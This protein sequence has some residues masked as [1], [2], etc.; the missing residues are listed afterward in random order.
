MISARNKI[1]KK[2]QITRNP[3]YKNIIKYTTNKIRIAVAKHRN[4]TW[5]RK[6]KKINPRDNSLWRMTKIF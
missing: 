2:W 5:N 1:R 4:D 6:L 3:Q